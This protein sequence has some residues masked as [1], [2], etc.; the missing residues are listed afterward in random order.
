M[1]QTIFIDGRDY[2]DAFDLHESI[3][4]M[5][6]FPDYYGHNADAL[7][8]CLGDLSTPVNVVITHMG[9]GEV[10]AKLAI[11]LQVFE[12]QGGKVTKL[13]K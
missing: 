3:A 11:C 12:D 8:D 7:N 9:D 4:M 1:T 5:L 2:V 13:C 6:D 10:A